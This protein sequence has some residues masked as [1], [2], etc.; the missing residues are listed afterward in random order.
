M[1]DTERCDLLKPLW[2]AW[3]E[4]EA[5]RREARKAYENAAANAGL[6]LCSHCAKPMPEY[7]SSMQCDGCYLPWGWF[8]PEGLRKQRAADLDAKIVAL[9]KERAAL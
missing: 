5:A 6:R 3:G 4:A 9:Q 7:D 8:T 1:N 2:D